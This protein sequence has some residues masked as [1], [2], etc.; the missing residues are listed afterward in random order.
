MV[1]VKGHVF[2]GNSKTLCSIPGDSTFLLSP[3]HFKSLYMV[4]NGQTGSLVR[5]A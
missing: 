1:V 5:P 2:N 4:S 3:L